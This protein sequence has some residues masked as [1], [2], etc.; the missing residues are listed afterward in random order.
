MDHGF[1]P[2]VREKRTENVHF[3]GGGGRGQAWYTGWLEASVLIQSAAQ[4]Q[5]PCLGLRGTVR[6]VRS[7]FEPYLRKQAATKM[8]F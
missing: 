6:V 7:H 4:V 5:D 2:C 3:W 1:D 8:I